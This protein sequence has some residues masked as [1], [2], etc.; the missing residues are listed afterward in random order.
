[1]AKTLL[2]ADD[3]VTI[4]KVVGISF[5]NEDISITTVD[6]GDDAFSKAKELRPD[7]VLADVVMPGKSGYEVCE[8]IK[9]D[10]ELRH[11]PVLLLTGTF[12][13]FD[14]ERAARIGAA[15]HVAKPFEAQTLVVRVKEL[16]GWAPAPA[17]AAPAAPEPLSAAPSNDDSFDFFDES[18]ENDDSRDTAIE[19]A[20][21]EPSPE[22]SLSLESADAAFAFGD[23]D[24]TPPAAP[25]PQAN[26]AIA[27]L[28]EEESLPEAVPMGPRAE[29]PALTTVD[30][31]AL[32]PTPEL[33]PAAPPS[34]PTAPPEPPEEALDFEFQ[35]APPEP[36]QAPA[37]EP[38][39]SEDFAQ[40][41]ILDPKLGSNFAV[42]SSDLD[43]TFS[44]TPA[45][46]DPPADASAQREAAAAG[47][48][49]AAPSAESDLEPL[50]SDL[51][52]TE[53]VVE[54]ADVPFASAMGAP[55][56]AVP[57]EPAEILEAQPV[58]A[59][60]PGP[61]PSAMAPLPGADAP[62]APPPTPQPA[63]EPMA[64][65]EPVAPPMISEAVASAEAALS[66]DALTEQI[67][68]ALR[69]ELHETLEKIAWESFGQMTERVVQEV[70]ERVETVAWDVVPKLAEALIREEIRKLKGEPE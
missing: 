23:E 1:M 36:P 4:Q 35:T 24:L 34:P 57:A 14:E 54:P 65:G 50:T 9:A 38:A 53:P 48:L 11:I 70:I 42:S 62:A 67:A 13:S 69:A 17:P 43:S 22:D 18:L 51:L 7:V 31:A 55:E 5:A 52:G 46:P 3:S 64:T 45:P 21:A 39:G 19:G 8:S 20:S 66:V 33:P 28:L 32:E 61:E 16:L 12:E 25:E 6:N 49:P 30:G 29:D 10:P 40:A 37:A 41:T 47:P 63:P 60:A 15:G 56:D 58:D 2:L 59:T 27:T 68:P 26:A 44:S